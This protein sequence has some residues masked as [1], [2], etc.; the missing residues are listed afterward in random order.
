MPK[1][2]THVAGYIAPFSLCKIYR[3][4]ITD[5]SYLMSPGPLRLHSQCCS[6]HFHI[7]LLCLSAAWCGDTE[8]FAAVTEKGAAF[9][10]AVI[11]FQFNAI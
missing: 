10:E 1:Q 6:A 5:N 11:Y 3:S 9:K 2:S 8:D 4:N 7:S